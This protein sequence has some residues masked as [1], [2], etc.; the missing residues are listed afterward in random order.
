M[1]N[2]VEIVMV[3]FCWMDEI[4]WCVGVCYGGSDFVCNVVGFIYVVDD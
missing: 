2:Y 3:G 1:G 4:C